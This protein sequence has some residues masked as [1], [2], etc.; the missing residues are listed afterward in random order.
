MA[1]LF[2]TY[3]E[4][5]KTT[6][7]SLYASIARIPSVTSA[8]SER[9]KLIG[10][11]REKLLDAED[12]VDGMGIA[13]RGAK[14]ESEMLPRLKAYRAELEDLKNQFQK[15]QQALNKRLLLGEDEHDFSAE[16]RA[17]FNG[18]AG[19]GDAA[20]LIESSSNDIILQATRDAMEME[21]VAARVLEDLSEQRT[22]MERFK[23]RLADI[24]AGLDKAGKLMQD[25]MRRVCGNKVMMAAVILILIGGIVVIVWLRFFPPA[26]FS[27]GGGGSNTNSTSTTTTFQMSS[28]S[29]SSSPTTN[30]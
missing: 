9:D 13:C 26:F 4:E 12:S 7:D 6:T 5:F 24:N 21:D 29:S 2:A 22:A 17:L 28:S 1:D 19:S 3:E 20:L 23:D 16:H 18:G 27:S 11:V 8:G 14:E 25:M 15:S 10:S 30:N